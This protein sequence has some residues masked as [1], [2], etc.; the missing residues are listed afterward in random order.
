M[1]QCCSSPYRRLP[2]PVLD[3]GGENIVPLPLLVP[4]SHAQNHAHQ[5]DAYLYPTEERLLFEVE[6]V[7][8]R[9]LVKVDSS[10]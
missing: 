6:F 5:L 2:E 7:L 10:P 3:Q 9:S 4:Y 8:I 1:L